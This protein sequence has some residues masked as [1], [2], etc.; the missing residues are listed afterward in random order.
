MSYEI[1]SPNWKRLLESSK[2]KESPGYA[3]STSG[4]I[5]LQDHGDLVWYRNIKIRALKADWR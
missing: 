3:A 1:K 2:Y 5:G 4:H